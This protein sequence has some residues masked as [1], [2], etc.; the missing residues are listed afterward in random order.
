MTSYQINMPE[1][2]KNKTLAQ[3]HIWHGDKCF[4]VSTINRQSSATLAYGAV[5]SETLVWEWD[6]E[7]KQRGAMVGQD[8]HCEDSLFAHQR[9][10]LRLF[11]TGSC[12]EIG[13]EV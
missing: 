9:M 1:T 3:T 6:D 10:V 5:Y 7:T 12:E 11:D 13:E 8:E 4:F 2:H